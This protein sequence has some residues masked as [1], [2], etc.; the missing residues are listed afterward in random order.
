MANTVSKWAT[1]LL[2]SAA[3][4]AA[5]ADFRPYTPEQ[6]ADWEATCAKDPK[7]APAWAEL[8]KRVAQRNTE[9]E[10]ECA[11][12]KKACP[13]LV[14]ERAYEILRGFTECEQPDTCLEQINKTAS[15]REPLLI[16][17]TWCVT[18]PRPCEY[19][20]ARHKSRASQKM[21]WCEDYADLCKQALTS[22]TKANEEHEQHLAEQKRAADQ[23]RLDETKQRLQGAL[24]QRETALAT[25]SGPAAQCAQEI[26]ERI[27]SDFKSL[28]VQWCQQS[29][30]LCNA[31]KVT[32]EE[33]E[34][35]GTRWCDE[36]PDICTKSSA[37]VRTG[38]N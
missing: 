7:C 8:K 4:I 5:H 19:V 23:K 33:R 14:Q 29:E 37:A 36:H 24:L 21:T 18:N 9:L 22:R 26:N 38:R 6:Q 11:K 20:K 13:Q 1:G 12:D 31:A 2:L 32:R 25:C 16:S 27:A 34:Q 15:E 3:F 10:N 17:G 30:E 28:E 35:R